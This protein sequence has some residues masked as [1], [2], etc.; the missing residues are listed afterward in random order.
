MD[1]EMETKFA[2]LNVTVENP[3]LY[4]ADCMEFLRGPTIADHSV[5]LVLNDPPYGVTAMD[6]DTPLKPIEDVWAAYERVLKPHGQVILFAQ[7][8]FTQ[9]M[10]NSAPSK[11][12]YYTLVFEKYNA[13][14]PATAQ[15]RPMRWHEDIIV[16]YREGS[17][18]YNRDDVKTPKA[19]WGGLKNQ[20]M[21]KESW[22]DARSI[23]PVY[24]LEK[25]VGLSS[26]YD[27]KNN[28]TRKP[29]K[30]MEWLL[31]AYSNYG[32]V[33]LDNTMGSGSTAVACVN[34]K[35]NCIA[36]EKNDV[37][38]GIAKNRVELA[39][40]KKL[41][42][43][44]DEAMAEK[45][46]VIMP[47]MRARFDHSEFM[48]FY[49]SINPEAYSLDEIN[50]FASDYFDRYFK[51][52]SEK[53]Y[54]I[55]EYVYEICED[56][57]ALIMDHTERS[58]AQTKA[59]LSK[60]MVW[61]EQFKKK[62]TNFFDV[63]KPRVDFPMY[64]SMSFDPTLGE[65]DET[66]LNTFY[67]YRAQ[68][69]IAKTG[70]TEDAP[71]GMPLIMYHL[72][73]L[74]GGNSDHVEYLLDVLA[75]P[76]QN[77]NKCDTAILQRGPQGCGK[78]AFYKEFLGDLVYGKKLALE[79]AGGKQIGG[80]FNSLLANR[81]LLVVD[82]VNEFSKERRN[83]LKNAITSGD[84]EVR[85]KHKDSRIDSDFT[86]FVF[87]CN[88]VPEDF[89]E[90][91][92]RRFFCLEHTGKHVNDKN[93]HTNLRAEMAS[94]AEE[95]YWMLKNREIVHFSKGEHPPQTA[96]KER[97]L[98]RAIDPV[99][100]YFR[101]MLEENLLPDP[102]SSDARN[103]KPLE[104]RRMERSK[105]YENT[106]KFCKDRG[107]IP[108][109]AKKSMSVFET[110]IKDKFEKFFDP[111]FQ[112]FKQLRMDG[113]SVP[114]ILFPEPDEL[115]EWLDNAKVLTTEDEL[116]EQLE[117]QKC[118]QDLVDFDEEIAEAEKNQ[119]TPEARQRMLEMDQL[120][121]FEDMPDV[122]PAK[123]QYPDDSKTS[124]LR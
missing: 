52:V 10:I 17:K 48:D 21:D 123:K 51:I 34:L 96:V 82:E 3:R 101:H 61:D 59:R 79:I 78:G 98:V 25:V 49:D 119:P 38:F 26:E 54:K 1:E 118:S 121:D 97:L 85:T 73:Q 108:S 27:G 88:D 80:D 47:P 95:F 18:V 71:T 65:A 37:F 89:L 104:A 12:K 116:L 11:W 76:I 109:W 56:G 53:E 68:N 105:F 7:N 77:G 102:I 33:I 36:I 32:D 112:M 93:Y 29:V 35:R 113:K 19:R 8:P 90:H 58:E 110:L 81:C 23:L 46:P 99:F 41:F 70:W 16:F 87:L 75:Y 57:T 30:T 107:I 103:F 115:W 62:A 4:H 64:Y 28:S 120:E 9:A 94:S 91:D 92:D 50:K 60:C 72:K 20:G 83:L 69:L 24:P 67:G 42:E 66:H 111:E 122:P 124:W 22:N 84:M 31:T 100:R 86:N 15:H 44:T 6:W 40:R 55:I 45:H 2:D 39:L 63:F 43:P 74:C 14:N 13:S 117:E 5:D 106:L 114:C